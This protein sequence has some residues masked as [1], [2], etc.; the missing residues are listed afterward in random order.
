MTTASAVR[1][2]TTFTSAA[3]PI[4]EGSTT[5]AITMA[6]STSKRAYAGTALELKGAGMG[7]SETL[8]N[9]RG[10]AC[11]PMFRHRSPA[12]RLFMLNTVQ[13]TRTPSGLHD[14]HRTTAALC[15]PA[16]TRRVVVG[17]RA[18]DRRE[19]AMGPSRTARRFGVPRPR[20]C[21]G[22]ER[23][24]G[25]QAYTGAETDGGAD[26]MALARHDRAL[27]VRAARVADVPIRGYRRRRDAARRRRAV[28][29]CGCRAQRRRALGRSRSPRDQRAGRIRNMGSAGT[30][31]AVALTP[32]ASAR[33]RSSALV[34]WLG[35]RGGALAIFVLLF[36]VWEVAVRAIGIKEYLLPAP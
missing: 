3:L 6:R 5:Q 28:A 11:I 32:A 33:L 18:P 10:D 21:G 35:K 27:R 19:R 16:R 22:H 23:T 8:V 25:R 29:T 20:A 34:A 30:P 15:R 9:T 2:T 4:V 7:G 1:R 26:R 17:I 14:A 12:A 36:V 13:S 31:R 24:D